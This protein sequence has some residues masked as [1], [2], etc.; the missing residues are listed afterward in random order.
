[1]KAP[2]HLIVLK[3]RSVLEWLVP[4]TAR[5]T[6]G[7]FDLP[8]YYLKF[9]KGFGGIATPLTQSLKKD[10]F[11]WSPGAVEAFSQRKQA[12]TSP[13]VLRLPKL[14]QSFVVECDV[15]G[16]GIGAIL[17]QHDQSVAFF[18]EAFKPS[19]L[20]LSTYEKEMLAIVKAI[21]KRCPYL[22]GRPFVLQTN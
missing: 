21:C 14:S 22:L 17:S 1:M 4:T 8:R 7:F 11:N 6:C 5:A 16:A 13:S 3:S 15:C 10:G 20:T 12:L 9:I 2:C 18:S 19:F